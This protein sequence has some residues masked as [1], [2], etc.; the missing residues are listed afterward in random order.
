MGISLQGIRLLARMLKDR[1]LSGRAVT[2]GVQG[3]EG[4]YADAARILKEEGYP[5]QAL[6]GSE[7]RNDPLTEFGDTL[8]QQ[9][10]FRMLG[11]EALES[12]DY[13]PD[14]KP[15]HL[16]NL[17][18]PVPETLHGRYDLVFDGGTM[19][20]CFNVKEVLFNTVRLLKPGGLVLHANPLSGLVNHGFFQFSP[21]L[22]FDF[23]CENGF[24][25]MDMKLVFAGRSLDYDPQ[26]GYNDFMGHAAQI[27][28]TARKVHP[29][30]ELVIPIQN[31]YREKFGDR[32]VSKAPGK[33]GPSL[34]GLKRYIGSP[35]L[36]FLLT[37]LRKIEKLTRLSTKL[38]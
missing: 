14:E 35:T 22:Y 26:Y 16:L 8:S 10:L 12:I 36:L 38:D 27:Y 32:K 34:A 7:I 29:S 17:N 37:S 21:T 5:F 18:E 19:E 13:F 28:F 31:A 33:P 23:Y 3:V 25:E 2:Y 24:A 20:H 1:N 4:Q 9:S 6:S 11:F 15:D 30:G